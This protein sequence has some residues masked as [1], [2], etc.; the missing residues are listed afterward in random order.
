MRIKYPMLLREERALVEQQSYM[1]MLEKWCE[2][3]DIWGTETEESCTLRYEL[4]SMP[5]LP[6]CPVFTGF[7]W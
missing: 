6:A 5:L 3:L 4:N 1:L 7:E 2:A